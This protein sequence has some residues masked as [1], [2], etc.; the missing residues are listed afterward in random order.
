M[1]TLQQ[2]CVKNPRPLDHFCNL[3]VRRQ[4]STR[5]ALW[6]SLSSWNHFS[7]SSS[8]CSNKMERPDIVPQETIGIQDSGIV[9][10]S[11][12]PYYKVIW[13]GNLLKR[14]RAIICSWK[15][16]YF[17]LRQPTLINHKRFS[18]ESNH[19]MLVCM[20]ETKGEQVIFID[21]VKRERNL[22][23]EDCF[24]LSVGIA[25]TR[26]TSERHCRTENPSRRRLMLMAMSDFE[27][28]ALLTCLRRILEPGRALPTSLDAMHFP[29]RALQM[30]D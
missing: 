5:N 27:A 29:A 28:I 12:L 26:A 16:R 11:Y 24:C 21:D 4:Q 18:V 13:H 17:Q 19:P 9:D 10:H 22:D 15:P 23:S 20:S 1:I 7:I 8:L 2:S 3:C 25:S 6:T 14:T 30:L